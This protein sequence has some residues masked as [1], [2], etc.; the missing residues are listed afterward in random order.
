MFEADVLAIEYAL[1]RL[2]CQY[3]FISDT[4]SVVVQ[5]LSTTGY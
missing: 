1:L 2:Q 4:V 3:A 5:F